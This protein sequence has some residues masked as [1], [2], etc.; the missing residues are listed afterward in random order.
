MTPNHILQY[1]VRGDLPSIKARSPFRDGRTDGSLLWLPPH[2]VRPTRVVHIYH[3][4]KDTSSV[5]PANAS[6]VDEKVVNKISDSCQL[7]LIMTNINSGSHYWVSSLVNSG[8]GAA[9]SD[10]LRA[11]GSLR[12]QLYEYE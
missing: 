1:V 4:R 8:L 5:S 3:L 6:N 11:C 10:D 7:M 2:D 12:E 9:T